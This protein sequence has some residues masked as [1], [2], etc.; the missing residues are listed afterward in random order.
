MDLGRDRLLCLGV[1]FLV[2]LHSFLSFPSLPI[3][4]SP[5]REIGDLSVAGVVVS[6]LVL[7]IGHIVVAMSR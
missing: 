5:A 3:C 6:Y 7:R 1:M 2:V 4:L